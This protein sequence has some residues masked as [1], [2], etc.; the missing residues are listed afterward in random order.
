M[1]LVLGPHIKEQGIQA[2]PVLKSAVTTGSPTDHRQ[3]SP[4]P[5]KSSP[6]RMLRDYARCKEL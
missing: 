1:L 3:I 5:P 6:W 4:S 2:F